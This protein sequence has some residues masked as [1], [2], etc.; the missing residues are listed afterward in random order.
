MPSSRGGAVALPADPALPTGAALPAVAASATGSVATTALPSVPL[1]DP[2]VEGCVP[3][4]LRHPS[5]ATRA[6]AI[7]LMPRL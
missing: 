6:K 7:I 3:F 2:L 1:L 4:E 5:S